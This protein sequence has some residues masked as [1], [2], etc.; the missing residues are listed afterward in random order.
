MELVQLVSF[1]CGI[2]AIT[3]DEVRRILENQGKLY[4]LLKIDEIS[5]FG[6]VRIRLRSLKAAMEEKAMS[7]PD[8]HQSDE[9]RLHDP[10]PG[11]AADSF[12]AHLLDH[13]FLW[14]SHRAPPSFGRRSEE[15]GFAMSITMPATP[16]FGRWAIRGRFKVRRYDPKKT[17]LLISQTGGGCRASNY[18]FL[19]RKPWRPLYPEVPVLSFNF[20]GL[21][22]RLFDPLHFAPIEPCSR[23]PT[24]ICYRRLL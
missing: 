21:E 13:E 18:I 2:D 4:T 8:F 19:I 15:A 3:S 16:P 14:L 6:A 10:D 1:G 5:S 24:P 11:H 17:A 20:S 12:H 22:K 7:Y 23:W 9:K